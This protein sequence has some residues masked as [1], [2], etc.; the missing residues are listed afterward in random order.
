MAM[1]GLSQ[2]ASDSMEPVARSSERWGARSKPFLMMSERM[3]IYD[4]RFTRFLLWPQCNHEGLKCHAI[5][6]GPALPPERRIHPAVVDISR[7][8][9]MSDTRRRCNAPSGQ[10]ARP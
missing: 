8:R 3:M 9:V 4:F 2:S 5:A 7:L 10:S 1:N 6:K